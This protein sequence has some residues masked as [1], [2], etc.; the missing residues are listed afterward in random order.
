M[1]NEDALSIDL[2]PLNP[3]VATIISK[4]YKVSQCLPFFGSIEPLI[5]DSVKSEC[6]FANLTVQLKIIEPLFESRQLY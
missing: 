6:V 1:M 3:Q 2:V 5:E 4:D